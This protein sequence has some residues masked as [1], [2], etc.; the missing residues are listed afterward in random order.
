MPVLTLAS[1]V[2]TD[3]AGSRVCHTPFRDVR[4]ARRQRY[5]VTTI[6]KAEELLERQENGF[7]TGTSL[8]MLTL[9]SVLA[10]IAPTNI[11]VLLVGE[12]GTGK[13]MFANRVHRLSAKGG[14][15][16]ARISCA[17]MNS[18]SF[19]AELGLYANA[20]GAQKECG[21][22][23]F[24]EIGELDSI[25]Q[26]NLLC[27]LPDDEDDGREGLLRARVV[28][29]T[30]RNLDEEMR[31][32]RFRSE[33]YYRINGV[34][35]RLPPLRE[36]KEDIA[37]LADFFLTKHAAKLGRARPSIRQQTL[38]ALMDYS[39]PGNIRELENVVKKIVALGDE[40]LAI[41]ELTIGA[42]APR[43]AESA[44]TRG[45]SLKVAARA[46]SREAERE[47]ILEALTRTRWNRKRAAQDLQISY[48][49]LLYKLKQIGFADSKV[50]S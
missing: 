42:P 23:F 17:A 43:K 6:N 22:V 50:N 46:A 31:A 13:E 44:A 10:E 8:A 37:L 3:C 41:A 20:M 27:A 21:T 14:K 35:L 19:S 48:K 36:R 9:E 34:C 29:T 15:A 2:Q 4:K 39:W 38:D 45:H 11:P 16:L 47:L 26:R 33:L 18:V 49:S 32:G 40:Q 5:F 12:S 25:C 1:G 30:S 7:V 24:D 28:S